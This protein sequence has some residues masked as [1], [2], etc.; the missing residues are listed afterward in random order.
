[1]C[2]LYVHVESSWN[3]AF[4]NV[5][6]SAIHSP[7]RALNTVELIAIIAAKQQTYI[8]RLPFQV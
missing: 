3:E 4:L 6:R 1:M 8:I 2:S 5:Q 7:F